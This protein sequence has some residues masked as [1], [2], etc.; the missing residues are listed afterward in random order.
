MPW[1]NI[2]RQRTSE[3]GTEIILCWPWRMPLKE[4]DIPVEILLER[5]SFSFS[6][7]YLFGLCVM[8]QGFWFVSTS[9]LSMGSPLCPDQ[10]RPCISCHYLHEFMCVH[11]T[12]FIRP[13]FLLVSYQISFLLT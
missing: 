10:C 13:C 6:G 4:F 1:P 3:H 7:G 5:T 8:C 2:I 9:P 12:V 11:S